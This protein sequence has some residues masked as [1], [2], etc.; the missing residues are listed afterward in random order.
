MEKE[1]PST[2]PGFEPDNVGSGK[3]FGLNHLIWN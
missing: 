2:A 3:N 1:T